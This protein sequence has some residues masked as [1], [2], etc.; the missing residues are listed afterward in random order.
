MKKGT[1]V[2][3]LIQIMAEMQSENYDMDLDSSRDKAKEKYDSLFAVQSGVTKIS[4]IRNEVVLDN[5]ESGYVI[6]ADGDGNGIDFIRAVIKPT[7]IL[8][9]IVQQKGNTGSLNSNGAKAVKSHFKA[10]SN[11]NKIYEYL[12]RFPDEYNFVKQNL[13]HRKDIFLGYYLAS[14]GGTLGDYKIY[15]GNDFLSRVGITKSLVELEM[16]VYVRLNESESK[17]DSGAANFTE[18]YNEILKQL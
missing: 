8:F 3:H 16:E 11:R 1:S 14:G 2:V 5:I 4:N 9:Q 10:F 7:Y 17:Y 12:D 6:N 13:P 18:V 15:G